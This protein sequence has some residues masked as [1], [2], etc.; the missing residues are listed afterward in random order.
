MNRTSLLRITAVALTIAFAANQAW[1]GDGNNSR[2]KL[3]NST[4]IELLGNSFL[5]S[6]YY[7]RMVNPALGLDAGLAMYGGGGDGNSTFIAFIPFG[8]KVY[9]IPKSGSIYLTGGGVLL[10]ASTDFGPVDEGDEYSTIYGYAGLGFEHR[11]ESGFVFR[12]TAYNMFIEGSYF[13]WP[14]LTLGYAF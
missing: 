11:A 10:T 7:Q 13:I 12:F 8:A 5:Y 3:R 1:A 4:G 9:L 6:F 2:L 14:G